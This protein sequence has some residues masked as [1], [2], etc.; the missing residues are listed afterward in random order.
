MQRLR[1]ALHEIT[2]LAANPSERIAFGVNL[3]SRPDPQAAK[4]RQG[5]AP[6]LKRVL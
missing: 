3:C 2:K 4:N 5:R 6:P 1:Q